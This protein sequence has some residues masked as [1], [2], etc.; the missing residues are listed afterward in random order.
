MRGIFAGAQQ[1]VVAIDA[2]DNEVRDILRVLA[3]VDPSYY[4]ND[5]AQKLME[6][7]DIRKSI[8]H[9]LHDTYWKRMWILQE[10]AVAHRVSL[11]LGNNLVDAKRLEVLEALRQSPSIRRIQSG[12]Q[13][14]R[15]FN[16]RDAWQ[17]KAQMPLV[18]TLW[19]TRSALCT[20]RHDRVFGL[21]GLVSDV[22]DYISEPSY[23][24]D[25][26][27]LA[28]SMTRSY[29][30][31]QS[32]DI[33]VLAPHIHRSTSIHAPSW[34]AGFFWFDQFPP[35]ERVFTQ[36]FRHRDFASKDQPKNWS[37]TGTSRNACSFR[38]NVLISP[39][40]YIGKIKSL[41]SAW[42][43]KNTTS[44]PCHDEEWAKS[45]GKSCTSHTAGRFLTHAMLYKEYKYRK[46]TPLW[47]RRT[48]SS[49]Q[50][51]RYFM[52]EMFLPSHGSYDS[53]KSSP[54]QRWICANRS[55]C[56]NGKT[57]EEHAKQCH[58]LPLGR[59]YLYWQFSND[60][61]SRMARKDM[62]MMFL[63][64]DQYGVGWAA[65]DA[66]LD[67]EVFLLRGC[68]VPLILR[69]VEGS[70]QYRLVGDAIVI[71]AMKNEI[72]SKTR[73]ADLIDVHIV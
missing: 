72:W 59:F 13:A 38:G 60:Q 37:A 41:G 54:L 16:V 32:I 11:L 33:V 9:Y 63:D 52:V 5:R 49:E 6:D 48:S 45:L 17:S 64:D 71:G 55:F 8:F 58:R 69:R 19:A 24:T 14:R 27:S 12:E 67:D 53:E 35:S 62:R 36:A 70:E 22:F 44:F 57:L 61:F 46:F 31:R 34:C 25:L 66:R 43:D 20:R 30:E 23:R 29:I 21:L 18:D 15:V 42:T 7:T 39:A 40:R 3:S 26:A 1:T 10:F 2:P 47:P 73:Q 50:V 65:K 28:I 68:S 4:G 51:E 56:V